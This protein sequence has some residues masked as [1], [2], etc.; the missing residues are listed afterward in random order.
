MAS[1]A[2]PN[3]VKVNVTM[4]PDRIKVIEILQDLMILFHLFYADKNTDMHAYKNAGFMATD[5]HMHSVFFFFVID[6]PLK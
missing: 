2:Q 5:M 1:G 6:Q 3:C 4:I